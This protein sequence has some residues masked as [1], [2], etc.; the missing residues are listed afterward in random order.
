MLATKLGA[1]L[2]RNKGRELV[3]LS[4]ALEVFPALSAA[5]VIE[6]LGR[7]LALSKQAISRAQ[8]EE[9]MFGKL[10]RADLLSDARPLLTADA[11]DRLDDTAARG[12]FI[13]VFAGFIRLLPGHPWANTL[14]MTSASGSLASIDSS[15]GWAVCAAQD[16]CSYGTQGP[17]AP[18]REHGV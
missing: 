9:R 14:S 10:K 15:R 5:R 13:A 2:Q 1:L 7:Y 17:R 16:E 8:A 18:N 3:D 12:A 6:L 11:A 4:H